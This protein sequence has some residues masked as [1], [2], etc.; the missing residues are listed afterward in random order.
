MSH[1][2]WLYAEHD[3]WWTEHDMN[4]EDE[5]TEDWERDVKGD[6]PFVKY[7]GM[8]QRWW[9]RNGKQGWYLNRV[10]D[11]VEKHEREGSL[12]RVISWNR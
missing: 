1:I 12:V 6:L 7:G 5:E 8:N 3:M 10:K 4:R 11:G 2:L 9:L